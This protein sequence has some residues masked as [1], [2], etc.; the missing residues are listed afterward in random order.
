MR[1]AV[2]TETNI[3]RF[4]SCAG[5]NEV[6]PEEEDGLEP[7]KAAKGEQTGVKGR[8]AGFSQAILLKI[9]H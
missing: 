8:E 5:T 3:S 4:S 9:P 6:Q 2:S 1:Q 7:G